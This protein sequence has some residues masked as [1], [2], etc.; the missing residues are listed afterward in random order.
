[1]ATSL[2]SKA[3]VVDELC[4][5]GYNK[6]IEKELDLIIPPL[7]IVIILSYFAENDHFDKH[8]KHMIVSG[9]YNNIVTNSKK[10]S[11]TAY[12]SQLIDLRIK[13]NTI[14]EWTFKCTKLSSFYAIGIDSTYDAINSFI[15]DEGLNKSMVT[16]KCYGLHG[17]GTAYASMDDEDDFDRYYDYMQNGF[18]TGDEIKIKL[19]AKLR[20][21]SFSK[22]GKNYGHIEK[23]PNPLLTYRVFTFLYEKGDQ[24]QMT[25]F[26]AVYIP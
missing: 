4:V 8:S 17:I 13:K 1:M 24:I 2:K 7:I 25:H 23:N 14:Y 6:R 11:H 15:F 19:N 9:E 18:K 16:R 22:N 21:I 20:T 10:G 26:D 3:T 12:G 5:Y